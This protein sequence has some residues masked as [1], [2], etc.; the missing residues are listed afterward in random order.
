MIRALL[1][2]ALLL[3]TATAC[4]DRSMQPEPEPEWIYEQQT[5]VV[6]SVVLDP[7]LHP[8]CGELL[9]VPFGSAAGV[10]LDEIV[11]TGQ[12]RVTVRAV[13]ADLVV[14]GVLV[15]AGEAVVVTFPYDGTVEVV[16]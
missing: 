10:T 5:S 6:A 11:P 9:V 1:P 14:L 2:L 12:D 8:H 4:D 16:R 15:L 13:G 7:L 3:A